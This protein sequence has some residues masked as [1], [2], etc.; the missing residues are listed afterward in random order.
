MRELLTPVETNAILSI[1]VEYRL[2][3]QG[4][5]FSF[6][7]DSVIYRLQIEV[8]STLKNEMLLDNKTY[9]S[10]STLF[11]DKPS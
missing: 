1:L 2:R 10:Q 9:N 7:I 4:K 8:T 5:T 6:D 11:D 3:N